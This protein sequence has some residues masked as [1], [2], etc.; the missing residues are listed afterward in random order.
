MSTF[1][2]SY[3]K[4]VVELRRASDLENKSPPSFRNQNT[5][6]QWP[7]RVCARACVWYARRV[8][9]RAAIRM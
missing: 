2:R 6:A 9:V 7:V 4:I 3:F 1:A 5:T 8:G